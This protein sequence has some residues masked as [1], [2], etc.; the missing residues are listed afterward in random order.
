MNSTTISVSKNRVCFECKFESYK[1]PYPVRA[2][3]GNLSDVKKLQQHIIQNVEFCFCRFYFEI[4][5]YLVWNGQVY[6]FDEVHDNKAIQVAI[7]CYKYLMY[8]EFCQHFVVGKVTDKPGSPAIL[9]G[10]C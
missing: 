7:M 2:T 8:Q 4:N 3:I 5:G 1:R 9:E 6:N 10:M